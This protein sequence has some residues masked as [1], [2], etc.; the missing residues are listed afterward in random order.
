MY[1]CINICMYV[2]HFIIQTRML[3]LYKKNVYT[4]VNMSKIS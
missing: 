3:Q 1:A 2:L 4:L